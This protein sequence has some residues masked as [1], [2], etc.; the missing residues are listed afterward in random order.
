MDDKSSLQEAFVKAQ[1]RTMARTVLS[2]YVNTNVSKFRVLE[3]L[4]TNKVNFNAKQIRR[5]PSREKDKQR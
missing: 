3:H 5:S 4:T 2:P 1:Q